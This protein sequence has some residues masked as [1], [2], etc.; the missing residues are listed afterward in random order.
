MGT[1]LKK[2]IGPPRRRRR[3]EDARGQKPLLALVTADTEAESD[4]AG[5]GGGV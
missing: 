2:T 4:G 3:E 5:L 1:F